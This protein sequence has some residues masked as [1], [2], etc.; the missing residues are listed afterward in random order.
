M[1]K[2]PLVMVVV[3]GVGLAACTHDEVPAGYQGVIELDE[4]Q[5]S[6]EVPGRVLTVTA[7]RGDFVD[8]AKILATLDD[9][10]ART[11]VTVR[12]AEARAA[13]E[14]AKLVA[15]GSRGEEVKALEAQIRAAKSAETYAKKRLDDDRALVSKGAIASSVIDAS[16]ASYDAAVAQ[17]QAL[18]QRL[19]ELRAGARREEVAGAEASASAALSA[20][21]LER[22]RVN[23]YQL[24]A[25]QPGEVL[26]VHI[27]PGEVVAPGTPILTIGDTTHPYVDVFV[28]QQTIAV[29]KVGGAARIKVDSL[30]AQLT[31]TVER[32]ARQTEFTPRYVFNHERT[33]LVIRVRVRVEDPQRQL[34]AGVPAFVQL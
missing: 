12:E 6:F 17:R 22:E 34:H 21:D 29:V 16:Q 26:D 24:H 10:Q 31:G 19:R 8:P 11:A 4:R 27:D 30:T 3:G 14:R 7:Q 23:R 25:V 1:I 28:P 32:I 13:Q 9:S 15:A 2:N 33:N 18:E 5:L 20:V